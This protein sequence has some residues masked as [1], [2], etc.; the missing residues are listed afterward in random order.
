MIRSLLNSCSPFLCTTFRPFWMIFNIRS[1]M[2]ARC[3][4]PRSC[5]VLD[6]EYSVRCVYSKKI[7]MLS[8]TA[9]IIIRWFGFGTVA[10]RRRCARSYCRSTRCLGSQCCRTAR[11]VPT[12]P[13]AHRA[14][15]QPSPGTVCKMCNILLNS[16]TTVYPSHLR[17]LLYPPNYPPVNNLSGKQNWWWCS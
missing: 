17:G 4:V 16:P 13:N 14:L 1:I 7:S 12:P 3:S 8:Y 6:G 11:S 9:G 10:L 2:F 5:D 15:N